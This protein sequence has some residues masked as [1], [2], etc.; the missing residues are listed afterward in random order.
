MVYFNSLQVITHL[1]VCLKKT[2]TKHK[3]SEEYNFKSRVILKGAL[4]YNFTLLCYHRNR[5]SAGTT[6]QILM[7]SPLYLQWEHLWT[8]KQLFVSKKLKNKLYDR[9]KSFK[10]SNS[11]T[12]ILVYFFFFLLLKNPLFQHSQ[13]RVEVRIWA[14]INRAEW[15]S[16]GCLNARNSVATLCQS[17]TL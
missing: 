9:Y 8:K 6:E 11:N 17:V 13:F 1:G 2:K 4:L 15:V 14:E 5:P 7:L 12:F 10:K 16:K 3:T